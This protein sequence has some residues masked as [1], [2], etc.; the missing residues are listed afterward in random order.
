[1]RTWLLFPSLKS[2]GNTDK[3][4]VKIHIAVYIADIIDLE[5][6]DAITAVDVQEGKGVRE[7]SAEAS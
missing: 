7:M 6:H 1:M 4:S 5:F 2:D 3:R